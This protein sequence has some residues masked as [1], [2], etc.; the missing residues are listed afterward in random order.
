[1]ALGDRDFNG[2]TFSFAGHTIG[3]IRSIKGSGKCK[4]IELTSASTTDTEHKSAAGKAKRTVTIAGVGAP[5]TWLS[6][7]GTGVATI[8]W[9]DTATTQSLTKGVVLSI[10]KEGSMDGEM[11]WSC[12]LAR[13]TT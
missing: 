4:D 3:L 10:D 11:T 6:E 1:M 12:E 9:K 13:T 5:S 7:G 8:T 2:S